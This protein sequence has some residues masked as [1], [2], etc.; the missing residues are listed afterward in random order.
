[1]HIYVNWF[2]SGVF[3]AKS[4]IWGKYK[5]VSAIFLRKLPNNPNNKKNLRI[6]PSLKK[7]NWDTYSG[8]YVIFHMTQHIANNVYRV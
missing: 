5:I 8:I 4:T 6:V 3:K 7:C 1:M 2:T